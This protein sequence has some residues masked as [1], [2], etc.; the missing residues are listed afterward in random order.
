MSPRH[1]IPKAEDTV[2]AYPTESRTDAAIPMYFLS[3]RQDAIHLMTRKETAKLCPIPH[4]T[5]CVVKTTHSMGSR[6]ILSLPMMKTTIFEI[7][8]DSGESTYLYGDGLSILI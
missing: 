5:R 7:L 1:F 4:T 8:V 6:G 2:Y 3:C